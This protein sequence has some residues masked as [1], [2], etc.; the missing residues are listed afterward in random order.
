[1]KKFKVISFF[2]APSQQKYLE[3]Y[4]S[5]LEKADAYKRRLYKEQGYNIHKSYTLEIK[6][7]KIV[8]KFG[9]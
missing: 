9:Y 2:E 5:S 7:K 8:A 3:R 1:M 6:S 4:F